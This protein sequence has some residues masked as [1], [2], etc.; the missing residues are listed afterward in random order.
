MRRYHIIFIL[1]VIVIQS[2]LL[3]G[4]WQGA[5]LTFTV[6]DGLSNNWIR[7]IV[8]DQDGTLW[9][10][11]DEG[12]SQY[13]NGIWKTVYPD[14][15]PIHTIIYHGCCDSNGALWFATYGRGACR[16]YQ[17]HW[18]LFNTVNSGLPNDTVMTVIEDH[19]GSIWFGTFGGGAS[20][21][22]NGSW[23]TYHADN[24]G[25]ES[26]HILSILEDREGAFWFGT[27]RDGV[28]RLKDHK[29]DRFDTENSG[30]IS[31]EVR[32]IMQSSDGSI[33]FGIWG[34]VD[35]PH[36]GGINR[37]QNGV[38]E[39]L[40]PYESE[41]AGQGIFKIYED[42][43]GALW[44]GTGTDGV[45]RYKDGVWNMFN[46]SNSGIPGYFVSSIYQDDQGSLWFG[47]NG[48]VSQ[49]EMKVWEVI[50]T[51]RDETTASWMMDIY[52]DRQG[53]IWYCKGNGVTRCENGACYTFDT[54]NS[55]L[56][57]NDVSVIFEDS[58]DAMWFGLFTQGINRYKDG[59]W[60]TFNRYNSGL[61]G[62]NVSTI[63]E[64]HEGVIWIGTTEKSIEDPG[65]V[66]C[67]LGNTQSASEGDLWRH[68][69]VA[70]SGIVSDSVKVIF[71]DSRGSFWFGTPGK[72]ISRF[73]N[74]EWITY[75]RSN[76]GL[77]H[78]YIH[79]IIEDQEGSIWIGTW[80]TKEDYGGVNRFFD[81]NWET[82]KPSNC[83]LVSP[84]ILE[85]MEDSKGTLWFGTNLGVSRLEEGLWSRLNIENSHLPSNIVLALLEDH[86]G[87]FWFGCEGG[88][89]IKYY[90]DD[91]PPV[92]RITS[93]PGSLV[94]NSTPVFTFQAKDTQTPQ[95]DITYSFAFAS[96]IS[97]YPD[98]SAF[99]Y[100][101]FAESFPLL[102]G[103]YIFYVRA[104]DIMGN[105]SWPATFPFT[106]DIIPPTVIIDSP[107][108][109]S[110]V[111]DS[112][113]VTGSVFDDSPVR[114]FG[115][116][117]LMYK[118]GDW[119][120][121]IEE[122][123][124]IVTHNG[125][126]IRSDTLGIWDVSGLRGSYKL[127]L[128]ATDS[129]GHESHDV[130]TVYIVDEIG[131]IDRS[132][133]GKLID[134]I[135]GI[136]IDFAPNTFKED[137]TVQIVQSADQNQSIVVFDIF[138]EDVQL[139]KPATVTVTYADSILNEQ[140]DENRLAIYYYD[141]SLD[142]WKYTG[143]TV[144]TQKNTICVSVNHLG[145]YGVFE[146]I[147]NVSFE[148][149]ADI[150]CQ[151]RVF[152]PGG[153]GYDTQTAISFSIK[154]SADVTVKVYNL[155]GRLK[156]C[157]L[158]SRNMNPGMNVVHWDGRDG[159]GDIVPG[160]LYIVTVQAGDRMMKKTVSVLNK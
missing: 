5:W 55:G 100:L 159:N 112:I 137:Q 41:L 45:Y 33:W 140:I 89:V 56:A 64:D 136:V 148:T 74:D 134:D 7:A 36:A 144:N 117:S 73:I 50:D 138:P 57:E 126:E 8:T 18:E 44:F 108:A 67:Y 106:V 6:K 143:G 125:N 78:D 123:H 32:D 132:Q 70:N 131:R 37:Y 122:W 58:Q 43:E 105:I 19:K 25:L 142:Q 65:G 13:Q 128:F 59:K 17:S 14:D 158:E 88:G 141:L 93:T 38:W 120:E 124:S 95:A 102:T 46:T 1:F 151:P 87:D 12:I 83:G 139:F 81:G 96:S 147:E 121:D 129:L 71:E 35:A 26:N 62:Y 110:T 9:V 21:L 109:G 76:S 157:V 39:T 66:S 149:W 3:Y 27:Y 40:I 119:S 113:S 118:K 98:Y 30:L 34:A 61:A 92:I 80:G 115:Y 53:A 2:L 146:T 130:V 127:Q 133:G 42:R 153:G 20:R 28:F 49:Y 86:Q 156:K 51:T 31:Y 10:G 60:Q 68:Y 79:S 145:C 135:L 47:S 116:Y 111:Y 23:E 29:W 91:T 63:I 54:G 154:K 97:Q 103:E 99:S 101:T 11:T 152:S 160:G 107:K 69:N 77:V 104:R 16:Y 15:I 114:D 155:S 94:G 22:T 84:Y 24:S 85:M 48:G 75:N 90:G 52:E 4:Q 72:G 82:Y 150:D